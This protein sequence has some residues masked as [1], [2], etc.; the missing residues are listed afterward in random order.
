[1]VVEKVYIAHEEGDTSSL[2]IEID[3]MS[4]YT[5][6]ELI[7]FFYLT[8]AIG[9]YLLEINPF[10]QPGVERYKELVNRELKNL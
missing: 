8:A 1:M 5:L 7:Y 2:I 9:G 4:E 10:D 3:E 6:G